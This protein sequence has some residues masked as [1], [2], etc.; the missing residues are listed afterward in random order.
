MKKVILL[1]LDG[2]LTNTADIAFKAMK[3]GLVDADLSKIPLITGAKE[4]VAKLKSMNYEVFIVSDSHSKYVNKIVDTYFGLPSV[5]LTDKPNITKTQNFLQ[6]QSHLFSNDSEFFVIGDTWLDIELGRGLGFMTILAKLYQAKNIEERDGIGQDRK[7]LKSGATFTAN[8]Y[9][10][11]VEIIKN[12]LSNLLC[13]EAIFQN[14]QTIKAIRIKDIILKD[15]FVIH[16][17]LGR[18]SAGEC[19]R[20]A[21]ADKYFE[22]SRADRSKNLLEKLSIA[23]SFYLKNVSSTKY[24]WD[25]FTYVP[26]KSTTIPPNKMKEFFDMVQTNIVKKDLL[27]WKKDISTSIRNE[28]TYENRIKFVNHNL[29]ILHTVDLKG[30]N[31]IVIDDQYTT[32]ATAT[33]I[34]EKLKLNGANNVLFI[35]LFYL[36]NAVDSHKICPKCSKRMQIKIRRSD[37]H[38]FYSCVLPQ[39]GGSG[40]GFIEN[41]N[42]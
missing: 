22:F 19:D 29:E 36:I 33:A 25:Y 5:N 23:V 42:N 4:F 13:V 9:D 18:Q 28:V 14:V 7:N 20:F 30:K 3:D 16:R 1:D 37:G 17:I 39:Y 26:D 8:S 31:I 6:T 2:T 34:C 11:I 27:S 35:S 10:E 41:I 38:R 12:P 15:Y 32:G 21:V 24:S 40:C